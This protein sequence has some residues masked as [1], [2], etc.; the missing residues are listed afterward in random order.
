MAERRFTSKVDAWLLVV[1]MAA[2]S[3]PL[4]LAAWRAATG[5]RVGGG[6][7]VV[8]VLVLLFTWMART[9]EY[10]VTDDTLTVRFG[11]FRR[12]RPLG[13]LVRLTS[14][15]SIESSPA[16]S[17]DRIAIGTSRGFWLNVSPADKAGFVKAIH[18]RAPQVQLDESLSQLL[19]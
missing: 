12:R 7:V 14:T 10:V 2:L 5:A 11:P 3:V 17:L 16:L 19:R 13:D 4:L 8:A 18:S 1:P 6:P 9:L 15:R